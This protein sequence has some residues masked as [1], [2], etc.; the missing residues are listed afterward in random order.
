[1]LR[2]MDDRRFDSLAAVLETTPPEVS[3][4]LNPR[5]AAAD[6]NGNG[7][8]EYSAD[9]IIGA[10]GE[11]RQERVAW[12]PRWGRY[13]AERPK[14]TFDPALH[15]GRYYVQ[16][17]SSMIYAAI[18]SR[19]AGQLSHHGADS[20]GEDREDQTAEATPLLWLDACAAPGG[21]ST[22]VIDALPDGSL[23][24]ANEYDYQRA[25]ILRENIAKWGYGGCVVCRGDTARFRKLRDTFDVIS[26]DA[27]CSGEGM[28][29]K[30]ETA[31]AQWSQALVEEC[32]ER[33]REIVGN[34]WDALRPGGY[35]IYSTCTFNTREDEEM[36]DWIR[37][38]FGAES[39]DLPSLLFGG[40]LPGGIDREVAVE[41]VEPTG[42][43]RFIP[44]RAR[45]EGLF[46]ALLRKPGAFSP[47]C[48][49]LSD[50]KPRRK[51]KKE[52]GG[53]G[54]RPD[55]N[56]ALLRRWLADGVEERYEIVSSEDGYAL[57]PK[58]WMPLL[59][60]L[61]RNLDILSAG[62]EMAVVK[63]KDLIPRQEFAL[64]GMVSPEAFPAVE[65]PRETALAYL[66][67]EAVTLPGD[68]PRGYLL[69][70][71]GEFPL[72][73]VNNIGNRCNNLYPK[74]WRIRN[75]Q[76]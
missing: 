53:G 9:G 23:V 16:D 4:R 12:W 31:R 65:I 20:N 8:A 72:G 37:S 6:S 52:K 29:R 70:T 67:R 58:L 3:I 61:K 48:S 59:G 13:L 49:E 69:L 40:E 56:T 57:F 64:S 60:G 36:V 24:V 51:G 68:N 55:S 26:V 41:G 7:G 39:V 5:M 25:E 71:F 75:L 50:E 32:V 10:D 73:F 38:Q 34:L 46:V 15:Q 11:D 19:L 74:E 42:S 43:L 54:N 35:L 63:G 28:M 30:D 76:K 45:G 66:A 22:A 27:P 62:V 1:M 33:Q 21:K 47:A 18:A 44:G 14:F 2:Q 17:A